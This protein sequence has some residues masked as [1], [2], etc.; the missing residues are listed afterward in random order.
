ME[1]CAYYV[2]HINAVISPNRPVGKC[3]LPAS[4]PMQAITFRQYPRPWAVA[5]LQRS[6]SVFIGE[7]AAAYHFL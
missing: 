6:L 4:L 1:K 7:R 5:P 2:Q 3:R